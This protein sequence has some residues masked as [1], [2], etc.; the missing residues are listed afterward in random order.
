MTAPWKPTPRGKVVKTTSVPAPIG[1]L[2][3][4][5]SVAAMP[6]TDALVLRNWFQF[7]YAVGMRKGWKELVIGM[8]AGDHATV[9]QYSPTLGGPSVVAYTGGKIYATQAA[10]P[11][12]TASVTGLTNDYW[13]TTM[14]TNVGGSYLYAVNGEDN[15]RVYDGVSFTEV[16]Q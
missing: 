6:I 3:S 11:A 12:P 10:G 9:A 2:N 1:G 4:R 13:Q 7:P 16:L 8:T 14:F 15:P 5:D